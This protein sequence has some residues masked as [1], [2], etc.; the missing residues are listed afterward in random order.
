LSSLN[1]VQL[2]GRLGKDPEVRATNSGNKLVNFSIATSEKWKDA[3]GQPQE[4]TEWHNVVC[5]NENLA[6]VIEKYVHKGDLIFVQGKLQTRK[7]QDQSGQDRYSTEV[8]LDQFSG[9]MQMLGSPQGDGRPAHQGQTPR[10]DGRPSA[11]R[12]SGAT[13]RRDDDLE[14]DIPF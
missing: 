8:V 10:S 1:Q 14:D 12:P 13:D 6:G 4:R 9:R 5:F 7:W 3:S 2:I 11:G